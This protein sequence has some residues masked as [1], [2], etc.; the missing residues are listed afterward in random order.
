M[1][2]YVNSRINP[3]QRIYVTF[4]MQ[5]A[6]RENIPYETFFVIELNGVQQLYTRNDVLAETGTEPA[7][8]ALIIGALLFIVDPLLGIIA[9]LGSGILANQS[10]EDRV[11]IFNQS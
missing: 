5:P 2:F 9:G 8:I 3:T 4:G 11:R 1:R 10:E 6:K 7:G